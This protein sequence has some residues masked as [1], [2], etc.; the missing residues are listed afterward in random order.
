MD[1]LNPDEPY[2]ERYYILGRQGHQACALVLHHFLKSDDD[3]LHTHPWPWFSMVLAGGYWEHTFA[4][5]HWRRPG[6]IAIRG[7]LSA[8]RV[9]LGPFAT[10][11]LFGM[12]PRVHDWFFRVGNQWVSHLEHLKDMP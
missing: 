12:G 11:T 3:K 4:G 2:L 9:E 7:P 5:R 8:H 6:S 10:W 1:H